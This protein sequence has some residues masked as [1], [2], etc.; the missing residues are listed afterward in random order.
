MAG[1][2]AEKKRIHTIGA[3]DR[4]AATASLLRSSEAIDPHNTDF[5]LKY[6]FPD[7]CSRI[8]L[9]VL[10]GAVYAAGSAQLIA[11]NLF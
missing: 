10:E 5:R 7:R 11:I 8:A 2:K 9:F 6:G 1:N 3:A 4:C